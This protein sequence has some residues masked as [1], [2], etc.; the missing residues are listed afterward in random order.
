MREEATSMASNTWEYKVTWTEWDTKKEIV[1]PRDWITQK[2][3][4]GWEFVCG[5]ATLN[6]SGAWIYIGTFRKPKNLQGGE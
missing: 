1:T 6:S 2:C 3:D 5:N 4:Q